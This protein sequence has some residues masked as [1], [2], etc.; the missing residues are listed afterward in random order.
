[1]VEFVVKEGPLF[2][3]MIMNREMQNPDYSFLFEN[4]SANHLYYRSVFFF[5]KWLSMSKTVILGGNC[6]V[7]CKEILRKFG[8]WNRSG[9][10][11]N[12]SIQGV[13]KMY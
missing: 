7:Y 2:E 9:I 3:A 5:F 4:K 1:M 11:S 8:E 10:I 6:L 12:T 13:P